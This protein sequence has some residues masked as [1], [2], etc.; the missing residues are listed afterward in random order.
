MGKICI[1]EVGLALNKIH[2]LILVIFIRILALGRR[3][4]RIN[5]IISQHN[6]LSLPIHVV[7]SKI[8]IVNYQRKHRNKTSSTSNKKPLCDENSH[9]HIVYFSRRKDIELLRLSLASLAL[10]K[11]QKIKHVYIYWDRNDPPSSEQISN[12][13]I[14]VPLTFKV[15]R[16]KYAFKVGPKR[17]ISELLAFEEVYKQMTHNDYIVKVDSDILFLNDTVFSKVDLSSKL[18]V[19]QRCKN[20]SYLQGGIYFL[21]SIAC[22]HIIGGNITKAIKVA[23]TLGSR[24]PTW[25]IPEDAVISALLKLAE[26]EIEYVDFYLPMSE[27]NVL[28]LIKE[29][30][31]S[32]IHY[33][34]VMQNRSQMLK[35]W[36]MILERSIHS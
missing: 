35:H 2:R 19:G 23:N 1:T 9:F 24:N 10:L 30:T 12:L 4:R 36:K 18:A 21:S 3:P 33:E 6:I 20:L 26:I 34:N 11:N 29:P 13:A 31:Q 32:I 25:F 7:L 14:S 16:T 15:R 8:A 5:Q 27:I 22:S 17:I 28:D